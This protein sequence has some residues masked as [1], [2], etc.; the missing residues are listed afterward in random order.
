MN[1]YDVAALACL[2]VAVWIAGSFPLAA[3]F[4]RRMRQRRDFDAEKD[5]MRLGQAVGYFRPDVELDA[6]Y[7]SSAYPELKRFGGGIS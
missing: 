7:R 4:A 3:W 5:T 2:L 1:G 6:G